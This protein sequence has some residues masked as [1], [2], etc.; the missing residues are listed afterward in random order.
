MQN[1][2]QSEQRSAGLLAKFQESWEISSNQIPESFRIS[3]SD[4]IS[5][6][7]VAGEKPFYP[8]DPIAEGPC[9]H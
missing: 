9:T 2:G 7:G 3:Q 4:Y 6:H 8:D 5:F 1:L